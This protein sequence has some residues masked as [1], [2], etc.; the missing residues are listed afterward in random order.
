M[1]STASPKAHVGGYATVMYD[2]DEQ[3]VHLVDTAPQG[4]PV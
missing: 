4:E 1:W 2:Y 3:D